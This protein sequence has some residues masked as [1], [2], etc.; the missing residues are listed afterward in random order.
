MLLRVTHSGVCHTDTHLR[1]GYY[2]LGRRG[3]LRLVDRGIPY[4]MTMGHEVVGV[5]EAAGPEADGVEAGRTRLVYPWIGCGECAACLD[6]RENACPKGRNLGVA[7]P[8]GYADHILV[9][10]PR[11]LLGI[12]DLDPS[13][14]ATLAC[15]GLTAYAAANKVLPLPP[16][17][18]VVVIGVGG[19]GLTAVATLHAL[20][21][22][23]ICA[24]DREEANL[25]VAAELGASLAV[26][27][28]SGDL[29]ADVLAATGQ[30]VAAVI[31]FV[32]NEQ[33][34]SAAFEVI[35]KGG[36]MVQVGL[37][38]GEVTIPTAL[39]ALKMVTIQGSFVGTLTE[40]HEV[41]E[42]AQQG[43][44][45]RI[46]VIDG[47]LSLDGVTDSLDRLAAAG[48]AG[49]IVLKGE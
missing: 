11:Y 27:A 44:V 34:A 12:G 24:V 49:R 14:A 23:A 1:A 3:K 17:A 9:P 43:R 41:V 37:F 6:G 15:S 33:T 22:R 19:V 48:V 30:P 36:R 31:D 21:H 18:P 42:L 10:H 35:V 28:G 2:D 29:A 8:G 39:L 25:A 13:W 26:P 40:L 16:E 46:P 47:K 4:P 45:P 32:N 38:G 20:G 7:R 5:V